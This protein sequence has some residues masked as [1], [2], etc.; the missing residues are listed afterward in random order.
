MPKELFKDAAKESVVDP[1]A[2]FAAEHCNV[3][4]DAAGKLV[5][6]LV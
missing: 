3:A 6:G 2:E 4:Y 5:E 1:V